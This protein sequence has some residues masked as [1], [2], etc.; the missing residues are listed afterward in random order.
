MKKLLF[1]LAL[2][3]SAF[4]LM[5]QNV[6]KGTVTD[7]DGNPIPG[8]KVEI[9]GG[10]ES[11]ITELDGTFVL[12][13]ANP[14]KK[15]TV[16]YAGMQS[17]HQKISPDMVIK[18]YNTN[19]W[20]AK[21]D[22]YCWFVGAQVAIPETSDMKPAFGLMIGRVKNLGWYNKGVY[23]KLPSTTGLHSEG[24]DNV[25]AGWEDD[26]WT[27]GKVEHGMWNVTGGVIARL[28]SPIH[29][30]AGA[31]YIERKVAWE[32]LNGEKYEYFPDSYNGVVVDLGLML[33]V[34]KLF[35]NA[36]ISTET[37]GNYSPSFIGN[38]GVGIFF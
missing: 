23:S 9:K 18:M 22:K 33:K 27:T 31:G 35:V 5:A 15:V 2:L 14:A 6:V 3:L 26:Y 34:N 21:P 36:G 30:Y 19:W 1:S 20:N 8:V 16:H 32:L 28:W 10:T 13:T 17:K 37:T 7:K 24:W 25:V 38:F 4:Q 12:E 29:I 11:T